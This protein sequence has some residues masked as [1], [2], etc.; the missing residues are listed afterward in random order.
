MKKLAI[1]A[2][3]S[4][5]LLTGDWDDCMEKFQDLNN[6]QSVAQLNDR[7]YD[8][9]E[10]K[11]VTQE[12]NNDSIVID[13]QQLLADDPSRKSK[14]N[15]GGEVDPDA[16]VVTINPAVEGECM[17]SSKPFYTYYFI[18]LFLLCFA[19]PVLITTS[20][21]VFIQSAVKN[22]TYEVRT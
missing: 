21:N 14:K 17:L 7:D 10:M 15:G 2:K 5:L 11:N 13:A 6:P 3:I 8:D 4:L 22:T 9:T 12:P 20:L 1:F 18:L 16:K 19:T